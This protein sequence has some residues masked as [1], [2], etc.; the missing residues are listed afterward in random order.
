VNIKLTTSF[1]T[2]HHLNLIILEKYRKVAAW[3]FACYEHIE[4]KHIYKLTP[5]QLEPLFQKWE[6]QWNTRKRDINNPK[7][8]LSFVVANGELVYPIP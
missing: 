1:S 4:I 7:I 2:H 8:P 6:R 3:F 5:R